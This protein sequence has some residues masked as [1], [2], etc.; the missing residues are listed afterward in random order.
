MPDRPAGSKARREA[1]SKARRDVESRARRSARLRARRGTESTPKRDVRPKPKKN[2]GPKAKKGIGIAKALQ[3]AEKARLDPA[4]R[5]V[6]KLIERKDFYELALRTGIRQDP[7]APR[8]KHVL[9]VIVELG[10]GAIPTI[11]ENILLSS[12]NTPP[13]YQAELNTNKQLR[14]VTARIPLDNE[15]FQGKTDKLENDLQKILATSKRVIVGVPGQPSL[16]A[17]RGDIGLP[18][19]RKYKGKTL[20]GDGV[21]VG[22]IDDGAALAHWNFLK[23]PQGNAP[24]AS[25]VQYIWD[26]AGNGNPAAGWAV[27]VDSNGNPDFDGLELTNP[28]INTALN[29]FVSPQGTIAEDEFYDYL[30]YKIDDLTSHGTHVMDVAA[31]NGQALMGSEGIAP[32]A[33]IVFVQLPSDA[34]AGGALALWPH[35]YDGIMYIFSRAKA[36]N[37]PAVVNIS[38]GGYEGPHD[39][40]AD[41]ERLMDDLLAVSERTIVLAVGNGFEADCHATVV[42]KGKTSSQPKRWITLPADPTPNDLEAWYD[43]NT[44]VDVRI[45]GPENLITQPG[46]VS[47]GQDATL[48]RKADGATVGTMENKVGGT[49]NQDNTIVVNLRA[50]DAAA[51]APPNGAAPPGIWTVEFRNRSNNDVTVHAWIHRDDAGHPAE[52]VRRQSRFHEDDS[53]PRYTISGWSGGLH[54]ISVGGF[55]VETQEVSRYSACGP[56]RLSAGRPERPK[57]ELLAPAEEDVRRQG[58]LCASSRE[59]DPTRMNGT[60]VAAPFVAGAIALIF[61]YSTKYAGGGLDADQ[62]GGA[63][64]SGANKGPLLPNRHQVVDKHVK[65]KQKYPDP[66]VFDDLIGGGKLDFRNT[67]LILF[68]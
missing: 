22:I 56:T 7:T 14:Y 38:Y 51:E 45:T 29:L 12:Y 10:A 24:L 37:K 33:D 32:G 59:A 57:P 41:L 15:I 30:G 26:Q 19:D 31:G 25:R 64:M 40:T 4:L 48:Y 20:T 9:P 6:L 5:L 3:S 16:D 66:T 61:E 27:P 43:G 54:T 50:T 67:M 36:L 52:S 63:L 39:G 35:L 47:I 1:R 8:A 17:A 53:S 46:W 44:T 42:V 2:S 23:P 13:A 11:I 65:I 62:I 58:V 60:S 28:K 21:V 34:I 55:N 68:P 18:I 49:P